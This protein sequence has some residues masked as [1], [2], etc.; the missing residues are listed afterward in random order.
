M[1]A[2]A[3]QQ[4]IRQCELSALLFGV[5]SAPL[6]LQIISSLCESEK[7]VSELLSEINTTQPNMSNHLKTLYQAGLLGKRRKGVQMYYY[8]ANP[9]LRED[10]FQ[11]SKGCGNS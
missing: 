2:A 6:R 3:K 9:H 5:L 7:N 1:P 10:I 11:I 8:L 4:L